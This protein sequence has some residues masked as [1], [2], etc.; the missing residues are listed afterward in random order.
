MEL[1]TSEPLIVQR[2]THYL[3]NQSILKCCHINHTF[4]YFCSKIIHASSHNE[5]D[6]INFLIGLSPQ[7]V[8]QEFKNHPNLFIREKGISICSF[9]SYLVITSFNGNSFIVPHDKNNITIVKYIRVHPHFTK[10]NALHYFLKIES[11]G[12][13][14]ICE[15]D[16]RKMVYQNN[17]KFH[18]VSEFNIKSGMNRLLHD[19]KSI[20]YNFFNLQLMFDHWK[21]RHQIINNQ[22]SKFAYEV[23]I[24]LLPPISTKVSRIKVNKLEKV[25]ELKNVLYFFSI[26]FSDRWFVGFEKGKLFIHCFEECHQPAKTLKFIPIKKPHHIGRMITALGKN[27]LIL[28]R[29]KRV[30]LVNC[31]TGENLYKP[32]TFGRFWFNNGEIIKFKINDNTDNIYCLNETELWKFESLEITF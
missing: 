20:S 22:Y 14:F 17:I 11:E 32:F 30:W 25:L 29:S 19:L 2:I 16:I 7:C 4:H 5:C 28:M 26:V 27:T 24:N 31:E 12:K 10:T 6:K 1:A 9:D 21:P 13:S 23:E 18:E 3:S 15:L 8:A